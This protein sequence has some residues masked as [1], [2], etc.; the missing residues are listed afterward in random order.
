MVLETPPYRDV[1]TYITVAH[2]Y[3]RPQGKPGTLTM[4]WQLWFQKLLLAMGNV[5]SK[6]GGA[7][8]TAKAASIATVA[9]PTSAALATGFYRVSYAVRVTRAASTSSDLLVTFGWT[10]GGVAMSQ[11]T[12][13]G[14]S[15]NTTAVQAHGTVLVHVDAKTTITYATTYTSVGA[16]AMQY[17][18]LILLEALL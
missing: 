18:L 9:V 2:G 17:Q 7:T 5:T 10:D 15:G 4:I 6:V 11:G 16:T 3:P 13:S 8:I 1:A 12:T 14:L